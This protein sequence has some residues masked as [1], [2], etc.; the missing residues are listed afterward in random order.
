GASADNALRHPT[1]DRRQPELAGSAPQRSGLPGVDPGLLSAPASG[2]ARRGRPDNWP[3]P[4][5]ANQSAAA[6]WATGQ[7][8]QYKKRVQTWS[9][10]QKEAM[11]ARSRHQTG[12]KR[13]VVF[14]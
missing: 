11:P 10:D 9:G 8:G 6:R 7:N 1:A 13:P 4:P 14:L 12:L 3:A 2:P 5:A